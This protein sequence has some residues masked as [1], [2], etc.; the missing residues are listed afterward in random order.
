MAGGLNP[1]GFT[2]EILS[3]DGAKG[4][5][6]GFLVSEDGLIVTAFH[7]VEAHYPHTPVQV[8]LPK[9]PSE[10]KTATAAYVTRPGQPTDDLILLRVGDPDLELPDPAP[11]AA[12]DDASDSRFTAYG[13]AEFGAAGSFWL[14]GDIRGL[15]EHRTA[16]GVSELI[17]L[18]CRQAEKG[19]SGAAVV[20]LTRNV[21]VGIISSRVRRTDADVAHAVDARLLLGIAGLAA[22]PDRA[23]EI[24]PDD[25]PRPE[26]APFVLQ[27]AAANLGD[28]LQDAPNIFQEFVPRRRVMA[29]CA[30]DWRD[31]ATRVTAVI[32]IGGEGKTS[33]A[34]R[35]MD[36]M[37]PKP[38]ARFWWPCY[39]LAEPDK[40]L[41]A[42]LD[43]LTAGKARGEHLPQ[44]RERVQV[45]LTLLQQV[46]VAIV[47]DGFEVLQHAAA[48]RF[49]EVAD[50]DL[51]ALLTGL[52]QLETRSRLLITTRF[53]LPDLAGFT[54]YQPRPLMRLNPADGSQLLRNFGVVKGRPEALV[55]LVE[56]WDGHAL[57]L[58]LIGAYL[59]DFRGGD[60]ANARDLQPLDG[61]SQYEKVRRVMARYD[62]DL[63]ELERS[64]LT[65]LSAFR[66]AVGK[67]IITQ[68]IRRADL[69]YDPARPLRYATAE[70][71]GAMLRRLMA[72]SILRPAAGQTL[73]LHPLVHAHYRKRFDALPEESRKVLHE[74]VAAYYTSI[75]KEPPENPTLDDLAPWIEAAHHTLHADLIT[76]AFEI[77]AFTI[78]G[79]NKFHLHML[80]AEQIRSNVMAEYLKL[81]GEQKFENHQYYRYFLYEWSADSALNLGNIS[82]SSDLLAVCLEIAKREN[83]LNLCVY[84]SSRHDF[85]ST[86]LGRAKING[87]ISE[88][89]DHYFMISK[90][91]HRKGH[92]EHNDIVGIYEIL[93]SS[94]LRNDC[95]M[96]E[97]V[98]NYCNEM[99]LDMK[100]YFIR[101]NSTIYPVY[102]MRI[103][104]YGY[105]ASEIKKTMGRTHS[106]PLLDACFH[107]CL[108]VASEGQYDKQTNFDAAVVAARKTTN[109]FILM[110]VLGARGRF[111]A[112][113]RQA[114]LARID[115]EEAFGYALE[116]GHKIEEVNI[117]VGLAWLYWAE[118][119]PD[120]AHAMAERALAMADRMGYAWGRDDSREVLAF[121]AK[122]PQQ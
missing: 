63:G 75:A 30:G 36:S 23:P 38:A 40:L 53:P 3:P 50:S 9:A 54:A 73:T 99:G 84:A 32:G 101:S 49:G 44:G 110:E 1:R 14:H 42:L 92:L 94:I 24:N 51:R 114:R 87:K 2:A 68:V 45:I 46:H 17:Q 60:P 98:I 39:E 62:R 103:G 118:K 64:F 119:R 4:L 27:L 77:F 6:T 11:L 81:D 18:T 26:L 86:I 10:R 122:A 67:E 71:F 82:R 90:S 109:K 37:D 111:L 70:E 78:E 31:A 59:R 47:I 106:S 19:M 74:R 120:R 34:R 95:T 72:L 25:L 117:R 55:E 96:R 116:S 58:S 89:S 43:W 93:N 29:D 104:G 57:T 80:G 112:Q 108:G 16:K 22:S 88:T 100:D 5:G 35:W 28:R 61:D 91:N 85:V 66:R 69:S 8:R 56:R 41:S 33:L 79:G 76:E 7:V 13:F 52:C 65:V 102:L 20:D 12:A 15:V 83:L 115:L 48:D 107:R 105:V 21:V 121:L 97:Y 113:T